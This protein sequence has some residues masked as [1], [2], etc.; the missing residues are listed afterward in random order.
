MLERTSRSIESFDNG[1]IHRDGKAERKK[2]VRKRKVG[3]RAN[4]VGSQLGFQ[5][6]NY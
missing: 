2:V 1:E 5:I 6:Q 3:L 4:C